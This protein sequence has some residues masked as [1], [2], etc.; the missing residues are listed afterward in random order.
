VGP[1]HSLSDLNRSPSYPRVGLTF[2]YLILAFL[3]ITAAHASE[4][5]TIRARREAAVAEARNGNTSAGL[6]ALISLLA[7]YPDDPA[8]LADTTIVANWAG[9]DQLVLELYLRPLTPKDDNGVVEAV[10][11]SARNLHDYD[12]SVELFRRAEDLDPARWQP[13]LGEA[14]A[15]TDKGDYETASR[16][17]QKLLPLH[18]DE[19]DVLLG[20]AYLC[21]RQDDLTCPIQMDQ[22]YL[23]RFPGNM[24]VRTELA[25][26]LSQVG[27]NSLASS[28]YASSV[29]PIAPAT[30]NELTG[31]A[32]GEET[33][34]AEFY[35]P[36]RAQQIA[37]GHAAL[38]ALDSVVKSSDPAGAT[39]RWAQF[40]RIVALF[41]LRDFSRV[42]ELYESL[43]HQGINVPAYALRDVAGAYLS[44]RHPEIAE[45]LYRKLLQQDPADGIVWGGLAYAQM[46]RGHFYEAL[47]TIDKAYKLAPPWL[48][49]GDSGPVRPDRIRLDLE[50]QAAQMRVGMDFIA[51]GQKKLAYLVAE[52]PGNPQLRLDLAA[53][54]LARGWPLRA[55]EELHIADDYTSADDL[56]SLTGAEINEAAGR[57]DDVDAMVPPLKTRAFDDQAFKRFLTDQGIERG[58][59]LDADTVFGWGSGVEVGSRDQHS[60]ARLSS[61]LFDNR[62][63]AYLHELSD[64]GSFIIDSAERTREGLGVHYDYA[65]QEAWAEFAHDTGTNRN[66]GNIGAKLNFNDFWSLRAE[67]DSDSFDVPVRAVTGNIHGRSL[68]VNLDWRG[69]ELHDANA[70]LQRVLFSDGNQRTAISGNW[71]QRV[72]TTPRIQA[73]LSAD[74][75]TSTN[76]LDENRPYFNPQKDFSLG[77]RGSL[78]W[79]TWRRY[80]RSFRQQFTLG[81]APYWQQNYG[82]GGS[83][84]LHYG[85]ILNLRPGLELRCGITW[86]T[87]PYDGS[88]EHRTAFESGITWGHK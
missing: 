28:Y 66:A 32:G 78:N 35:A 21:R 79:L 80:D 84:A 76:S 63:R 56:P 38:A 81:A 71:N 1:L 6:S 8:L 52:T 55:L 70:G 26:S 51:Q 16:L 22:L 83:L 47:A 4:P 19:P 7:S 14:M 77:P 59:R 11:R 67:A 23:D 58:W 68:D 36:T 29:T 37:E 30:E 34:W 73:T 72:W 75:W 41:D 45:D 43:N 24:E 60:E 40:D 61:P 69:S 54:Y 49:S 85:Q 48:E 3:P 15:L 31:A 27:S 46:D 2:C 12:R 18:K 50:S 57:R 86:N 13:Q 88:N 10:A 74:E 42:I 65:R 87:Q 64:S 9:N 39:W 20:Q 17:M 53:A 25:R 44:L 62:W 5:D 33:G 82:T